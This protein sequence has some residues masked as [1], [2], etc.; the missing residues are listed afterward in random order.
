MI[1][2]EDI[3]VLLKEEREHTAK[4]IDQ[5]LEPINKKLDNLTSEVYHIKTAIKPLATKEDVETAIDSAKTEILSAVLALDS[6]VVTKVHK[7]TKS[8]NALHEGTDV[9]DPNTH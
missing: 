1:T 4:I 2:K 6:K 3:K 9:P 8:I 5:K 7:H